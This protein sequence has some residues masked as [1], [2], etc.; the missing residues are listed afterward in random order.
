MVPLSAYF[1]ILQKRGLKSQTTG[2]DLIEQIR[3][4]PRDDWLLRFESRRWKHKCRAAHYRRKLRGQREDRHQQR[5]PNP[6]TYD[7]HNSL[8]PACRV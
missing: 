6:R 2:S 5:V 3:S 8:V 4:L 7:A 1:L